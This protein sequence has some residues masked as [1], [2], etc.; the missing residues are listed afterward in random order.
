MRLA[1]TNVDDFLGRL[2]SDY[3]TTAVP[4]RFFDRPNYFRI[5]MGVD[6]E[7]FRE[8]LCRIGRALAMAG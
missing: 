1:G 2:R 8:G 5:G 7:M 3:E 4:G 6:S